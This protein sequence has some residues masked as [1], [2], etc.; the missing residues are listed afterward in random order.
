VLVN[1]LWQHHFGRGIVAS[2]SDFGTMGDAPTH[3]QLLDWLATELV[4]RS[5]SLKAMHRLMV[6]SATYRQS[7]TPNKAGEVSLA[8]R[9]A[10]PDNALLWTFRR[11]RLDGEGIRDAL[12]EVSGQ[13]NL[14]MGG[15]GVFPE[16]PAELMKLSSKGAIWP[17]SPTPR[18]RNRRGLYVF[19]RRNLRY[20]FFEA[21][22]RPDTNASCPERPVT[23][24]APQALSLL[25]SQLAQDA[26][27]ALALRILREAGPD[28]DARISLAYRLALGRAP[29]QDESRMARDFLDSNDEASWVAFSLALL[30][31]NEFIYVD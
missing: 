28:K 23:T 7:S 24:I 19:V 4:A 22:D 1:R 5:W 26:A 2:S 21:F 29:D 30:N 11:R 20:P 8:A 14:A 6:T 31:L 15:P 3:P 17:V 16:L 25:N 9:K 27:H 18:E 13:L 12:L 10:D